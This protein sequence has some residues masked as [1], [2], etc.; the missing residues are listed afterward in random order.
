[1]SDPILHTNRELPSRMTDEERDHL[2]MMIV[3]AEITY[4]H[5]FEGIH[6][7]GPD[8]EIVAEDGVISY[9][10]TLL[11]ARAQEIERLQARQMTPGMIGLYTQYRA[12]IAE[13]E[14][15]GAGPYSTEEIDPLMGE[16]WRLFIA[17]MDEES[18]DDH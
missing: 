16:L 13:S 11:A 17:L 7:Q 18:D 10:N 15:T 6:G 2:R 3:N 9:V 8:D 1:M 5:S 12:V 4:R 14:R